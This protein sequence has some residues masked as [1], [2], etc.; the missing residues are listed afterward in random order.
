MSSHQV[1]VV[2]S[3]NDDVQ[4]SLLAIQLARPKGLLID[5]GIPCGGLDV[6]L[7]VQPDRHWA[8]LLPVADELT[9]D[10]LGRATT[11]CAEIGGLIAAPQTVSSPTP[12]LIRS[13]LGEA[14]AQHEHVV[15]DVAPGAPD[16]WL[17]CLQAADR[18]ALVVRG[19]LPGLVAGRRTQAWLRAAGLAERLQI[20]VTTPA[21]GSPLG[22]EEISNT[23]G[24]IYA[25]LPWDPQAVAEARNHG[26]PGRMSRS[27]LR[28]ALADAADRWTQGVPAAAPQRKAGSWWQPASDAIRALLSRSLDAQTT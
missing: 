14:R 11:P 22:A 24:P 25:T 19:D 4:R 18:I 28:Q 3:P 20:V 26:Q 15:V 2:C 6:L 13:L 12:G 5:F 8:D 7:D 21:P 16:V 23:L 17:A 9:A 1:T 10:L 27:P